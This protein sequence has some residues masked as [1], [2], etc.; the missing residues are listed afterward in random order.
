MIEKIIAIRNITKFQDFKCIGN[1]EM[2]RLTL[3]YAE[4]GKGKSTL[5]A[6][7]RS[8]SSGDPSH[9]LAKQTI[10]IAETPYIQIK[11]EG[12]VAEFK[13]Q[14][15]TQTSPT[16]LVFDSSYVNTNIFSGDHVDHAHKKNLYYLLIGEQN[17]Q[18]ASAIEQLDASIREIN[19]RIPEVEKDIR[20]SAVGNIDLRTFL[21]MEVSSDI[22]NQI[23][24][25]SALINSL[26]KSLEIQSNPSLSPIIFPLI[27]IN[28]F[29]EI[30]E[31]TIQDIIKNVEDDFKHHCGTL[32]VNGETWIKDGFDYAKQT[33]GVCPFCGQDTT[34]STLVR[35]YSDYFSEAYA[36]LKEEVE[37]FK[38]ET[39]E[40]FS[41]DTM[42]NIQR[43]IGENNTRTIF[44]KEHV[45]EQYPEID[46]NLIKSSCENIVVVAKNLLERK[47]NAPL[48]KMTFTDE[49]NM[50]FGNYQAVSAALDNYNSNVERINDLIKQKQADI[51]VQSVDDAQER[52][53]FLQNVKIRHEP[54]MEA[55]CQEYVTLNVTKTSMTEEKEA[56]RVQ[57]N[58]NTTN[59]IGQYQ[60][61]LNNLL[62]N[63][64]A[65]FQ[66]HQT[67]TS[68]QGGRP[69]VS[70]SL[71]IN[72]ESIPLGSEETFDRPGFKTTLSDGEKNTLAF[73]F[74]IAQALQDSDLAN[75]IVVI[76]DPITSLDEHRKLC[77]KQEILKIARAAKQVIVLSHDSMFLKGISEDFQSPKSL[78]IKR[79]E[80]GS[81]IEEWDIDTA[82]QSQ[83]QKDYLKMRKYIDR[84]EG[85]RGEV[86]RCIRPVLEGYLRVRFPDEFAP[87][88]WLGE[89]IKK[90]GEIDDT[91]P[92]ATM[93]GKFEELTNINDFSKRFHHESDPNFSANRDNVTDAALQPWARRTIEFIRTS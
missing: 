89:F 32:G 45:A 78:I 64:G 52:M 75:K 54:F 84:G 67:Q 3:F 68:H 28:K 36:R 55:F 11:H 63:F 8:F 65:D 9:I 30:L 76:D 39:D 72:G 50:A 81:I 46:F 25:L 26:R 13:D 35:L 62:V 85:D 10:G 5:A 80:Q 44:W 1:I 21:Q 22:D 91:E 43:Q 87:K 70:Y 82:T 19:R 27:N 42:M 29:N 73:A 58:Q 20:R 66:I 24:K 37:E 59:V 90:I 23:S 34:P 31:K 69:S 83:Y 16:I 92:L 61:S 2:R 86:A 47:N 4:N 14:V 56:K 15:W 33:E 18:L 88:E 77:T 6:I 41:V 48:E 57:L 40:A 7:F 38:N 74:F 71:L 49:M 53:I 51:K 60:T 17:V 79:A 93:K 12:G